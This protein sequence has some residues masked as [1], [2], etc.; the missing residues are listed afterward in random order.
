MRVA[1]RG[2]RPRCTF[3][4]CIADPKDY[5]TERLFDHPLACVCAAVVAA[6]A[7]KLDNAQ[8][9]LCHVYAFVPSLRAPGFHPARAGRMW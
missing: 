8:R 3:L 6:S 4:G 1:Q 9:V 7:S 2:P 5:V